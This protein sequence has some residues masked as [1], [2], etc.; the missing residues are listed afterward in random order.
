MVYTFIFT[1]LYSNR[2]FKITQYPNSLYF[3][4][5]EFLLK[6]PITINKFILA[7]LHFKT[8]EPFTDFILFN[9]IY[10]AYDQVPKPVSSDYIQNLNYSPCLHC[11]PQVQTTIFIHRF[12]KITSYFK[13]LSAFNFDSFGQFAPQLLWQSLMVGKFEDRR[14]R[15][16]LRM[17]WLDSIT[18]SMDMNLSTLGDSQGQGSMVCCSPWGSRVKHDIATEQLFKVL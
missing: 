11:Q 16:R 15:G 12:S 1:H 7:I 9:M 2:S 3:H 8:T 17:R 13:G 4:L 6:S 18:N 14:R 5:K 10:S